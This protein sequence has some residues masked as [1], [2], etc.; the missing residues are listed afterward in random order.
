MCFKYAL[1]AAPNH[2]KKEKTHKEYQRLDPSEYEREE[3]NFP[4]TSNT[5]YFEANNKKIAYS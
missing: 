4:T 2:E 3:I 5:E 1:T